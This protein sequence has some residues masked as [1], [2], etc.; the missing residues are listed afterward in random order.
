MTTPRQLLELPTRATLLADLVA[1]HRAVLPDWAGRE[2]SPLYVADD[3]LAGWLMTQYSAFN[4]AA[5]RAMIATATGV[6]LDDLAAIYGVE[7]DPGMTDEQV[8]LAITAAFAR[9]SAGTPE[10]VVADAHAASD[11]VADATMQ[12]DLANNEI[13]VWITTVPPEG[14]PDNITPTTAVINAVKT[15]LDAPVRRLLIIDEHNVAAATV[16]TYT[17][18]ATVTYARTAA[19]PE[20][21]SLA[22]LRQYMLTHRTLNTRIATSALARAL[23]TPDVI[24]VDITAPAADMAAAISTARVGSV[25]TINYTR[26]T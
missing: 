20:L 1:R 19:S 12:T 16:A 18:D 9:V 13:D 5:D 11:L 3:T 4:L 7:R 22:G 2:T 14:D 24:D 6:F 21:E 17:V 25:G 8:R 10:A 23:W 26:E 15:Y